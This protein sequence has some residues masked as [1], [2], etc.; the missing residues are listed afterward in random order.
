MAWAP[1]IAAKAFRGELVIFDL[2]GPDAAA[3]R[4]A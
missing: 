4:S 1:S 3:A 2:H